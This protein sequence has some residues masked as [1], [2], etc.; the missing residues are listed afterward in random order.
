MKLLIVDDNPDVVRVLSS[1]AKVF[2]HGVDEA[3][4]GVEAMGRLQHN[5]YDVVITDAE[6][7]RMNGIELCRYVRL[8][9]PGVYIIGISGSLYSLKDLEN[10]GADR[11]LPKPFG[12]D[13]LKEAIESRFHSSLPDAA[14]LRSVA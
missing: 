2:G 7:P 9:F 3:V 4:D 13:E 11:C 10:A 5:Q 14:P 12:I 8:R 6:M 1:V